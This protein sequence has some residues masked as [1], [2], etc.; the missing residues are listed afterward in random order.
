[1]LREKQWL[2]WTGKGFSMSSTLLKCL[3]SGGAVECSTNSDV[4]GRYTEI[5]TTVTAPSTPGLVAKTE[6]KMSDNTI[7]RSEIKSRKRILNHFMLGKKHV[8]VKNH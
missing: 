1:M 7:C 6:S 2:V 3:F 4:T 8:S 5:H